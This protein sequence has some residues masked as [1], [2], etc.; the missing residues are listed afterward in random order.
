MPESFVLISASDLKTL[1]L[2]C[3]Y[4]EKATVVLDLVKTAESGFPSACP[5]CREEWDGF[6]KTNTKAFNGLREFLA[7]LANTKMK[8]QF[9]IK[10]ADFQ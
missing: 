4:C 2:T 6:T 3:P 8:P 9:R 5:I 10:E 1:E 7:I